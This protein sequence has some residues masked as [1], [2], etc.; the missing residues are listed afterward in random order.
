MLD[1]LRSRSPSLIGKGDWDAGLCHVRN[2]VALMLLLPGSGYT[3]GEVFNAADGFGVTWE[4]YIHRL[5]AVAGAPAPVSANAALSRLAAPVLEAYGRLTKRVNRPPVTRQSLRLLG[6]PN[7]FS[8]DKAERCLGY[9]PVI[10]FEE[11][12]Q[13]L[14]EHFGTPVAEPTG[15]WIWVTGAASGLGRHLVGQ[16]LQKNNRVLATDQHLEAL[17]EAAHEERWPA[18][19]VRLAPLD[20]SVRKQWQELLAKQTADGQSFS[21]LLNVAGIIR[22]GNSFDNPARDVGAQVKVN[23]TGTLNGCDTLLPHF[24][25][26]GRG[27]IINIGSL[28]SYGPVPGVVGY[29]VSKTAVR[30]FSNG[31]AMDLNLAGSPVKV[32]CVCPDLIATPMM[33]HQL[34]YGDHARLVFSGDRPLHV[35]E[36]V[37]VILGRVWQEQPMEVAMPKQRALLTAVMGLNPRIALAGARRLEARGRDNLSR[38]RGE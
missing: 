20:V 26:Q 29:T 32:T 31:L 18:G 9:R 23:L 5:A 12:M 19:L 7:R 24:Q 27:H 15:P 35:E 6:G 25:E 17:E 21:H 8:I 14:A 22:P 16:L 1:M 38:M 28:A 33:D 2:L 4:T 34:D 11:A 10:G 30:A 36:V 37:A 13:E 3:R